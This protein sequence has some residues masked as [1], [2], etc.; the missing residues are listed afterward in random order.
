DHFVVSGFCEAQTGPKLAAFKDWQG[1]GRADRPETAGPIEQASSVNA[2]E[3]SETVQLD[4]GKESRPGNA[5]IG[6]G[7]SHAA[8]SGGDVRPS[9]EQ[10]GGKPGRDPRRSRGKG[11]LRD[12]KVRGGLPH[13]E[14]ERMLGSGALEGDG[15][16]LGLGGF[17]DGLRLSNIEI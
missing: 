8:F 13:E 10:F 17:E 16:D 2:L 5:D 4:R 1:Q 3:T 11:A 14:S 9:L 7:R 6:I 15:G 12:A